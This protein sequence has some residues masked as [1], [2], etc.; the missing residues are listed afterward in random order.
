M[1]VL[2]T[3]CKSPEVPVDEEAML[4]D[5]APPASKMPSLASFLSSVF[6]YPFSATAMRSAARE[7]FSDVEDFVGIL[8]VLDDWITLWVKRDVLLAFGEVATNENG[9]VIAKQKSK[10]AQRKKA[11]ILPEMETVGS[12]SHYCGLTL[13]WFDA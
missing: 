5:S 7:Y 11:E 8:N 12:F 2:H 6:L 4:I 1:R 3:I 10:R 9:V 13:T